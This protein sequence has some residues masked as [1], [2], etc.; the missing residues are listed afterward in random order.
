MNIDERDGTIKVRKRGAQKWKVGKERGK[1][2]KKSGG[3]SSLALKVM[4]RSQWV[5]NSELSSSGH[6]ILVKKWWG[7][8][9]F[10]TK[11]NN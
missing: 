2:K 9:E 3:L 7:K 10:S 8:E 6:K 1:I 4:T 11:P 5:I